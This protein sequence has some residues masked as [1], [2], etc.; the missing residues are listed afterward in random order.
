MDTTER[1]HLI[2]VRETR[3]IEVLFIA[4]PQFIDLL[5]V[6]SGA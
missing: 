5:I 4:A 6:V 1:I 3:E 2:S